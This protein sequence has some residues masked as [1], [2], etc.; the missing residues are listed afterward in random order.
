LEDFTI[1]KIYME[2]ETVRDRDRD[3][4]TFGQEE[5]APKGLMAVVFL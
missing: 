1:I 5:T 3:S 2:R 4:E